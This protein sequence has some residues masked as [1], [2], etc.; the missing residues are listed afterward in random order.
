MRLGGNPLTLA[1]LAGLGDLVLTCT[2]ELSRNRKV[3]LAL[4][5]GRTAGA[6]S[7]R[8][9]GT[10]PRA[11][12]PPA[13]PPSWPAS[14]VST[15]P[16]PARW[17]RCWPGERSPREAVA[18]L[19]ARESG[20]ERDDV[21]SEPQRPVQTEGGEQ[22]PSDRS[23]STGTGDS[24]PDAGGP[25]LLADPNTRRARE[26]GRPRPRPAAH[27]AYSGPASR[28]GHQRRA[29]Q[30][31]S[32][33]GQHHGERVAAGLA[34][35]RQHPEAGLRVVL[36]PEDGDGHEVG[37]LPDE[38]DREQRQRR[39]RRPDRWRWPSP[40]A[41]AAPRGSAPTYSASRRAPLERGV[42][43]DVGVEREQPQRGHQ[44][45]A[46]H[47]H[48]R[49]GRRGQ[50]RPEGRAPRTGPAAPRAA[51]AGAVRRISPSTSRS[52][53][54]LRALAAATIKVVPSSAISARSAIDLARGQQQAA[55]E[56]E[57]HQPGDPRLGTAAGDRATKAAAPV[58]AS[59]AP[60][61]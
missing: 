38:H 40:S 44:E 57:D 13:S 31:Q 20:P 45:A 46:A 25:G 59:A 34:R 4:A 10:W 3:G 41:A 1:G 58:R 32:T 50:H 61:G 17:Q 49:N 33:A 19:L 23:A 39:R 26:P 8:G 12:T 21:R 37:H 22:A 48:H 30:H 24:G 5:G 14:W 51:G 7:S 28:S 27:H 47:Q 29:D 11:S 16:S 52:R 9:W 43:P 35:E 55:A 42:A 60:G 18:D 53:Y 36:G 2:G 6:R 54:M 15:C 56:G